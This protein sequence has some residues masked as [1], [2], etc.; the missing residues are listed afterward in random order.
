M[1]SRRKMPKHKQR[2]HP[3][4]KRGLTD[5]QKMIAAGVIVAAVLAEGK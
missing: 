5:K 2:H 1:I 3:K 4:D